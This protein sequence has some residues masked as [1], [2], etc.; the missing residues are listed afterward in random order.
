MEVQ[1][2]KAALKRTHSKRCREVSKRIAV[3]KRLECVRLQRRFSEYSIRKHATM[4][5]IA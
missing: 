4:I 2:A 1:S 3:A 5:I